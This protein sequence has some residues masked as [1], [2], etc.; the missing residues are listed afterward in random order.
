MAAVFDR[1]AC[2]DGLTA[3]ASTFAR[4]DVIAA[5]G[6]QLAGA[7]RA[8]LEELADRFLAEQAVAVVA[9]RAL[10]ERRWSTPELLA[11][12]QRLVAAATDRTGEQTAVV[13]HDAVRAALQAHPTAGED[14]QAMVGMSARA[15]PAWRWWSAGPGRARPSPWGWP[16]MPGSWTATGPWPVLPPGSPPSAWRPRGSR[17]SPPATGSWPTW[18][19]AASSWT[20]GRC[21]WWT[22]PAC[23]AA[24][25]SPASSSTPSRPGPRWCWSAMTGSWPP[26]TPAAA[27][28]PSASAWAPPS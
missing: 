25:S 19:A 21:W 18:T 24:A 7:T 8:E 20:A 6:G 28:A 16:G 17:R 9:E 26:S 22:R 23:S 15:A 14:Q 4:Q 12:E 5:L 11:V 2:P 3:T 27:S 1:L 10:E 13:C